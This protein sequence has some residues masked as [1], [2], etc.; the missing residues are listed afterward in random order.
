VQKIMENLL[1]MGRFCNHLLG[2]PSS[3][4]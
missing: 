2:H 1:E 4:I 3:L